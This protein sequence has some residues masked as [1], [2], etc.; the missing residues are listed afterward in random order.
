MQD[1]ENGWQFYD[2]RWKS[3]NLVYPIISTDKPKLTNLDSIFEKNKK[4]L[5]WAEQGIGDQVLYSGMLDQLLTI[6][7]LSQ[8]MLD[9]RLLP[10]FQRSFSQGKYIPITTSVQNIEYD[11][12]LPIGDLG[13]FF[14][15]KLDDFDITRQHYLSADLSQAKRN[16]CKFDNK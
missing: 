8:I 14:R 4:L 2:W 9:K 1:F 12:H 10:L 3:K 7:P 15:I 13:K 16:S 11:E 5:V 6:A